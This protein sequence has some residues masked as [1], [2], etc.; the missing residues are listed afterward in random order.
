MSEK[1]LYEDSNI[2]ITNKRV[3][4]SGETYPVKQIAS[5]GVYSTKDDPMVSTEN[6]SG[7]PGVIFFSALVSGVAG[8][9]ST[10]SIGWLVFFVLVGGFIFYS[11]SIKPVFHLQ[12]SV[13]SKEVNILSSTDKGI[14]KPFMIG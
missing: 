14:F 9:M 5:V 3:S 8:S 10:A 11:V 12:L 7:L 13:S 2:V 1:I 6:N 4:V